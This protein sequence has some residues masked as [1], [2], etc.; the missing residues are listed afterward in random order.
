[1][2]ADACRDY[3]PREGEIAQLVTGRKAPGVR[4]SVV[5]ERRLKQVAIALDQETESVLAGPHHERQ[6]PGL[7]ENLLALVIDGI[8]ALIDCSVLSQNLEVL[9][10]IAIENRERNRQTIKKRRIV[11]A[12]NGTA[13]VGLRIFRED[14]R[15]T[16][17][18][19]LRAHVMRALS[20]AERG[21][22]NDRQSEQ[23]ATESDRQQ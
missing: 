9:S 6:F 22:Y 8:L 12:H 7:P 19:R 13:H 2:T 16:G 5:S 20:T 15:V 17:R 23:Q 21:P 4:L 3:G 11:S 14:L 1:V 10:G 18:A